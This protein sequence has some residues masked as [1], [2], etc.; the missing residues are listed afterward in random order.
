MTSDNGCAKLEIT[1]SSALDQLNDLG[2]TLARLVA[3]RCGGEDFGMRVFRTLLERKIWERRQTFEEFAEFV[4]VFAR[5]RG[6]PGS[7]SVRHLQRLAGGRGP[8][9]RPIGSVRPATARLLERIFEVSIDEL[10]APPAEAVPVVM[11]LDDEPVSGS[12]GVHAEQMGDLAG[13]LPD[14]TRRRVAARL[15]SLDLGRLRDRGARL[16]S[17]GR[18]QLA[19]ALAEYYAGSITPYGL[20]GVDVDGQSLLTSVLTRPEWAELMVALTSDTDRIVL[21]D[22]ELDTVGRI[23]HVSGHQA[24][25]QLAEAAAFGVRMTNRP[26]VRST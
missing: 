9:G 25:D 17:V 5:D 15:E 1:V 12:G 2:A 6:E 20:Y 19:R 16:R 3:T 8:G 4:E 7:V 13:W 18:S 11:D 21:A 24:V 23:D 22:V 10:L 14:S 26:P